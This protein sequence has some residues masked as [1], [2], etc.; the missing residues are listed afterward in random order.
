M[1]I[2]FIRFLTLPIVWY[3]KT[4]TTEPVRPLTCFRPQ[5]SGRHRMCWIPG[6]N[7]GVSSCEPA[8]HGVSPALERGNG[9]CFPHVVFSSLLDY[10]KMDEVKISSNCECST[11]A[12]A[13]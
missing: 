1:L 5:L 7:K 9:S 6:T 13:N 10:Q 8:Q 4:H 12:R 2:R 11:P 3:Y